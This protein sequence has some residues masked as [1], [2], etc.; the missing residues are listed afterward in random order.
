[1]KKLINK[2]SGV[3]QVILMAPVKLP[4]KVLGILKYIGLGLGVIEM[5][6]EQTE[7]EAKHQA[8]SV[9]KKRETVRLLEENPNGLSVPISV[10]KDKEVQDET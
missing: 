3:V 10:A 2:I 6:L 7:D 8:D 9:E 4:A 1:M 5:V